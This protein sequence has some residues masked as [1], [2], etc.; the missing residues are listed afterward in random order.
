MRVRKSDGCLWEYQLLNRME[1]P[2]IAAK[3]PTKPPTKAVMRINNSEEPPSGNNCAILWE[4][5]LSLA[6]S[7]QKDSRAHNR[8]TPEKPPRNPK[9]IGGC[10][11]N[12]DRKA[13]MLIDHH[14]MYSPAIKEKRAVRSVV[15]T[16]FMN[17][18][19]QDLENSSVPIMRLSLFSEGFI[20][21][22]V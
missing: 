18:I 19:Y 2:A 14:G 10:I 20:N 8:K 1:Q 13:I 6:V 9:L 22:S 17:R 11:K 15:R 3:P 16:N 5:I 21:H 4:R 7:I 12:A